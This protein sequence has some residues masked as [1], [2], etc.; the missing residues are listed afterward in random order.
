[1]AQKSRINILELL[2][3]WQDNCFKNNGIGKFNYK[4]YNIP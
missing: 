3:H 4:S 1:M 2:N